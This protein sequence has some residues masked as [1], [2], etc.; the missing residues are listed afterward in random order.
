M[1]DGEYGPSRDGAPVYTTYRD[2][3]HCAE[4]PLKPV[5]GLPIR[6]S[7]DQGVNGAAMIIRQLLPSGQVRVLD[8]V[9]P[10]YRMGPTMFAQNCR[11]FLNSQYPGIPIQMASC[12]MAGF[13]GGDKEAGD[14]AWADIVARVLDIIITPAPTNELQPRIDCV[15]QL[16]IYFPDQQPALLIS[17][18][19]KV[20]RKGFNSHY[21]YHLATDGESKNLVPKKNMHANAMDAL[22]Y[23]VLDDFGLE[24]VIAGV[25]SGETGRGRKGSQNVRPRYDPDDDDEGSG[26]FY[27][28]AS[29]AGHYDIFK[30]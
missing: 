21:C 30:V 16:L 6:L 29:G 13:A 23:G 9:I 1:V 2:D 7:F 20:L 15:G 11:A 14:H 18:T 22:Q 12:D 4:A 5:R 24:G 8:E 26:K 10:G 19:C 28:V 17:P 3:I 25:P 27:P